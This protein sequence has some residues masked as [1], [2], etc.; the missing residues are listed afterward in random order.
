MHARAKSRGASKCPNEK[1]A[2]DA[3]SLYQVNAFT[4]ESF[5]GNPAGLCLLEQ[6]LP[7]ALLQRIAA[8]NKLSETAFMG[9]VVLSDARGARR[10]RRARS[11]V[12]SRRVGD[13]VKKSD[14][15]P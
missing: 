9:R 7:D 1:N 15:E 13:F 5:A 10:N 12:L 11:D 14:P 4:P 3:N 8:E 2:T 6:W